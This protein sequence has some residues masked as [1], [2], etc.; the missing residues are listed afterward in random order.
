MEGLALP[1]LLFLGEAGASG[2]RPCP[3][4]LWGFLA[5]CWGDQDSLAMGG[6]ISHKFGFYLQDACPLWLLPTSG[7]P[8]S[9]SRI[10]QSHVFGQRLQVTRSSLAV[11]EAQSHI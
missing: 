2:R 7:V 11:R 8:L 5:G 3:G 4:P 9:P 6:H 1:R 10:S